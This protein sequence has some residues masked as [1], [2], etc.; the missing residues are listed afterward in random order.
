MI[1]NVPGQERPYA[2][3]P[4]SIHGLSPVMQFQHHPLTTAALA[5]QFQAG[6]PHGLVIRP[7]QLQMPPALGGEKEV[8]QGTRTP[9]K[10]EQKNPNP[11]NRATP[12]ASPHLHAQHVEPMSQP[13]GIVHSQAMQAHQVYLR[14]PSISPGAAFRPP[15][16]DRV[17]HS[18]PDISQEDM[19]EQH[20]RKSGL[21]TFFNTVVHISLL[22][23]THGS[24]Y[25]I[26][27]SRILQDHQL[28]WLH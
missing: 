26:Q 25:I 18:Q 3:Y 22:Y 11:N 7:T 16:V 24:C 13:S 20:F 27:A 14:P 12:N 10:R 28:R 4:P 1:Q 8:A 23:F 9:I 17:I 21:C 5:P 15:H 6:M 19:V 2:P